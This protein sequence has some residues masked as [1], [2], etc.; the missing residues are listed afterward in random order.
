MNL[1]ERADL[2]GP[3]GLYHLLSAQAPTLGIS[4]ALQTWNTG[5]SSIR[6]PGRCTRTLMNLVTDRRIQL[7]DQ[8]IKKSFKKINIFHET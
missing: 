8:L 4:G 5:T 7:I 6:I 2:T 3:C 1:R